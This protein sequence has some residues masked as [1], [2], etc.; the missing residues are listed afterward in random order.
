MI[1]YL[2]VM[3]MLTIENCIMTPFLLYISPFLN[4]NVFKFLLT[5]F[6]K[7]E[8]QRSKNGITIEESEFSSPVKRKGKE[9]VEGDKKKLILQR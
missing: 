3:D 2:F 8:S 5:R 4:I 9:K 1:C 7:L 6:I